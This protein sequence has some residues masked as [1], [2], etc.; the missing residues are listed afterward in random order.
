MTTGCQTNSVEVTNKT[1]FEREFENEMKKCDLEEDMEG[2][3][4]NKLLS[5]A[6]SLDDT[7]YCN[8]AS[9]LENSKECYSLFFLEKAQSKK[10]PAFCSY[11]E[12]EKIKKIC[13]ETS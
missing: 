8:Y 1:F 10:M 5:Q 3:R 4:D 2:C 13:L 11:I 6:V 12:N 7:T 9:N